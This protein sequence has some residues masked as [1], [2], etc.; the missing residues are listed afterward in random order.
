MG[1]LASSK[2]GGL[3]NGSTIRGE[4]PCS[5]S[6]EILDQTTLRHFYDFSEH[7]ANLLFLIRFLNDPEDNLDALCLLLIAQAVH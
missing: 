5:A 6:G 4:L 1:V 7:L 3:A 2:G